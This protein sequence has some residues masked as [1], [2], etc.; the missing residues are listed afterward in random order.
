MKHQ[1]T[2]LELVE[3]GI[4]GELWELEWNCGIVNCELGELGELVNLG[5]S[6]VA[7]I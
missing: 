4:V 6:R 1:A 2:E 7:L 5:Q 3:L